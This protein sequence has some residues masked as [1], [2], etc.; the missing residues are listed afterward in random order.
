MSKFE[1]VVKTYIIEDDN[2]KLTEDHFSVVSCLT[3]TDVMSDELKTLSVD[4]DL[5]YSPYTGV[6]SSIKSG[7][8]PVLSHLSL[9]SCIRTL[10]DLGNNSTIIL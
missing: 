7:E 3:G 8:F 1:A 6:K 5:H 2:K 10:K 9:R 4:K